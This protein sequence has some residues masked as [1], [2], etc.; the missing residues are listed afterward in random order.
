MKTNQN[1]CEMGSRKGHSIDVRFFG[2]QHAS[3]VFIG[4]GRIWHGV[5]AEPRRFCFC[6]LN[7]FPIQLRNQSPFVGFRREMDLWPHFPSSISYYLVLFPLSV[8]LNSFCCS[9]FF[10]FVWHNSNSGS[11]PSFNYAP[12][13]EAISYGERKK[14]PVSFVWNWLKQKNNTNFSSRMDSPT[15]VSLGVQHFFVFNHSNRM[16]FQTQSTTLVSFIVW[17]RIL[18]FVLI[19]TSRGE[20]LT[21]ADVLTDMQST[22]PNYIQS[23]VGVV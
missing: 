13:I 17:T 6:F 1:G 18:F 4:D 2:L 8:F 22:P 10:F 3:I 23:S 11:F 5:G 7:A 16:R 14:K 21:R 15:C 20:L 19:D 9:N 12:N